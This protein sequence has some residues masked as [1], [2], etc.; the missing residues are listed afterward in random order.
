VAERGEFTR[1]AFLNG[2]M[3]LCQAEAVVDVIHASSERALA[4]A[5]R[6]LDGALGRKIS[7]IGDRLLE[8]L[9][10]VEREI[11]FLEEEGFATPAAEILTNLAGITAE[12]EKLIDGHRHRPSL[13]RGILT[14]ILGAPNAGK[15]SLL[16]FLLEEKRSIVDATAGTTRDIV[17]EGLMVGDS[18]L[19]ICDT[20]G[21]RSGEMGIV[22]RIGIA[23]AIEKAAAADLLL[24]VLDVN[25]PALPP[26]PGEI[27]ESIDRTNAL[28]VVNKIDLERNCGVDGFLPSIDRF[29]ISLRNAT[30]PRPL[31]D[32]ILEIIRRNDAISAA[33]DVA[34]NGRQV[35]ILR[36]CR[37]ALAV[38]RDTMQGAFEPEI[39]AVDLR[40]AMEILGEITGGYDTERLLDVI[41]SKFCVGK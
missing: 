33:V 9:A 2:K 17:S 28:L 35:D 25:S 38:A 15:S 7:S 6:Q 21:L 8:T 40:R 29:E 24:F 26:I 32:K 34:V 10:I 27:V 18:L 16:N 37:E 13:D 14:V 3:D 5:R 4:V 36:R 39:I 31:K 20:A 23:M 19:K 1:R 41:F 11:D 22:E 12:L 30:D